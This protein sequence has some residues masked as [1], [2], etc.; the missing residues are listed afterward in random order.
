M[1]DIIVGILSIIFAY[2]IAFLPMLILGVA[3]PLLVFLGYK[4][5]SIG[6]SVI[7]LAFIVDAVSMTHLPAFSIGILLYWND[8]FLGFAC[9]IA[10]LRFVFAE[11]FPQRNRYWLI[12]CGVLSLSLFIGMIS[13][14]SNAGVIARPYFYFASAGLYGMSFPMSEQGLK[15]LYRYLT[16]LA[17]I[18]VIM[19]IA[20]WIVYYVP[21]TE[22][23]PDSG[24]FNVDG[25]I[26]VIPSYEA[27]VLAEIFVMGLFFSK[28]TP[29]FKFARILLPILLIC[30]LVLQHRSVWLATLIGILS[31]LFLANNE[32]GSSFS[33]LALLVVMVAIISLPMLLSDKLSGVSDQLTSS[34]DR[35]LS[36]ADT[37]GE[38]LDSW[39]ELI[40][41]W[42]GGGVKSIFIGQ[43]FGGD[44]SRYVKTKTGL[45]KITY[46][47]HNMYV[48]TLVNT[49]IIGLGAFL[50][51][52]VFIIKRL[53]RIGNTKT[54]YAFYA[55]SLLVLL[56][57]QVTYY[58]PYGTDYLQC[59]IMGVA[60][61]YVIN[62]DNLLIKK[63]EEEALT[64]KDNNPELVVA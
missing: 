33:Q 30:V 53:Y 42:A 40:K 15:T 31:S 49:G 28:L 57:M 23:L 11:D 58:V 27:L 35:A 7:F 12:F 25:A 19:T 10:I 20:R 38:R 41:K 16:I 9:L 51:T 6:M 45:R 39:N 26:R 5:F 24:T 52:L 29:S 50:A 22:L 14:G 13:Y 60:L 34:A 48:Q 32:K 61:A 37:T 18:L 3:I 54:P 21:V 56:L 55:R 59:L 36:G 2:S 43:S 63:K 46:Q 17:S 4:R 44:T 47:A 64:S 1:N 8:I 62:V